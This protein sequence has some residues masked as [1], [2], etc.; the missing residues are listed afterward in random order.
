MIFNQYE[1]AVAHSKLFASQN[2]PHIQANVGL[3]IFAATFELFNPSS[4]QGA[5]FIEGI[6]QI[7]LFISC[8]LYYRKKNDEAIIVAALS[9]GIIFSQA[10]MTMANHSW[11][12]LWLLFPLAVS[13]ILK[14]EFDLINYARLTLA[15]V[16]FFAALQKLVSG[17][18][19]DGSFLSYLGQNGSLTERFFLLPCLASSNVNCAALVLVSWV[20]VCW[21]FTIAILLFSG[22]AGK[23]I[24]MIE[25]LFFFIVALVTDELNFLIINLAALNLYYRFFDVERFTYVFFGVLFIDYF[26]INQIWYVVNEILA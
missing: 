18:Y 13:K 10:W 7:G 16:M 3:I 1:G 24:V 26:T 6:G 2:T 4:F 15:I 9:I 12:T 21:Q 8:A 17:N 5:N 22:K 11:L 19:V 23:L 14:L 25:L 20:S